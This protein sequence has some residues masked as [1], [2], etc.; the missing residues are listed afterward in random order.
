MPG[1]NIEV[2]TLSLQNILCALKAFQDVQS[3]FLSGIN[4]GSKQ[5]EISSRKYSERFFLFPV[6]SV[7]SSLESRQAFQNI[8]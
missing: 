5:V 8:L 6:M 4:S 7:P 2:N 3:F 1:Q